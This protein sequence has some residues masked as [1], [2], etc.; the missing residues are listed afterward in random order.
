[1]YLKPKIPIKRAAPAP[2]RDQPLPVMLDATEW[3]VF[4]GFAA[5]IIICLALAIVVPFVSDYTWYQSFNLMLLPL[6]AMGV[7]GYVIH[8]RWLLLGIASAATV[9]AIVL[10]PWGTVETILVVFGFEGA[11]VA[12]DMIQRLVFFRI[13][14]TI[15]FVNGRGR[16]TPLELLALYIFDI[17]KGLDTRRIDMEDSIRRKGVTVKEIANRIL[18]ALFFC[19]FIWMFMFADQ[20]YSEFTS[21]SVDAV[22]IAMGYIAIAVLSMSAFETLDVRIET[23]HGGFRLYDGL[24]GTMSRIIIPLALATV[25][26]AIVLWKDPFVLVSIAMSIVVML[27][28]VVLASELYYGYLESTT[29]KAIQRARREFMPSGI[30]SSLG[31][32]VPSLS[33][34]PPGTPRRDPASCFDPVQVRKN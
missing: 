18:L 33:D 15:E 29:V 25:L 11:A 9:I 31:G 17:P 19:M 14:R 12:A 4:L 7:Y 10:L 26:L 32:D 13:L 27:A 16:N 24:I 1:M 30:C 8:R 34:A 21:G 22:F 6:M 20:N 3:R 23:D 2:E 28:M 5:S